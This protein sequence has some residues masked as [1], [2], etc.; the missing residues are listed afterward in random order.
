MRTVVCNG[1]GSIGSRAAD[2]ARRTGARALVIDMD[3]NCLASRSANAVIDNADSVLDVEAGKVLLLIGDGTSIL[4]D[5]MERWVPDVV[6]PGARGHMAG[7]LAVAYCR[8]KG[9]ELTPDPDLMKS[10]IEALP[11]QSIV[12]RD[13]RLAVIATSYMSEDGTCIDDCEQPDT[14]PVTGA[15]LPSP[16]HDVIEEALKEVVDNSIILRTSSIRVMGGIRGSGLAAMLSTMG[17]LEGGRTVG[18]ATACRCHGIIN[19]FRTLEKR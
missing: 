19:L 4:L 3:R 1:G 10:M 5:I 16:M 17:S 12:L 9:L 13:H 11:S 18:V 6:V 7:H 14:C 15:P 8:S 2:E